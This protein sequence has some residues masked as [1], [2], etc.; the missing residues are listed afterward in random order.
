MITVLEDGRIEESVHVTWE[1]NPPPS[2]R[3]SFRRGWNSRNVDRKEWTSVAS[4]PT[5]YSGHIDDKGNVTLTKHPGS[6]YTFVHA[7]GSMDYYRVFR[8]QA[9]MDQVHAIEKRGNNTIFNYGAW[10]RATCLVGETFGFPLPCKKEDFD[11]YIKTVDRIGRLRSFAHGFY[12]FLSI[13][14]AIICSLLAVYLFTANVYF[15]FWW[16]ALVPD[17]ILLVLSFI[18]IGRGNS[19]ARGRSAAL[20]RAESERDRYLTDPLQRLY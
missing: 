14:G 9:H 15:P 6:T 11:A 8:D 1:D 13:A 16:L 2:F 12:R 18:G 7:K 10:V 4:D 19:V 5:T 17:L 3:F 20:K